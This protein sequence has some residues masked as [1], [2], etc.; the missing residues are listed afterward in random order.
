MFILPKNFKIEIINLSG[1]IIYSQ[2]TFD[3]KHKIINNFSPGYYIIQLES[4]N[5]IV[6]ETLI[7][8]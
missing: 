3:T 6:R 8:Q 5:N 1:K 2:K 7:V 4:N